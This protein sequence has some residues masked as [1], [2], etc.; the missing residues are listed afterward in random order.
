MAAT[1]RP[2]HGDAAGPRPK[3]AAPPPSVRSEPKY[4]PRGR[5]QGAWV[6]GRCVQVGPVGAIVSPRLPR[7]PGHR[8]PKCLDEILGDEERGTGSGSSCRS[9]AL[10][11]S[12]SYELV[13]K[14]NHP[15][16][17]LARAGFARPRGAP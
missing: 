7:A 5:G 16:T 17:G 6:G 2:T 15:S 1:V 12:P 8:S 13:V 14:Q 11:R 10:H 9:P 3:L 4:S